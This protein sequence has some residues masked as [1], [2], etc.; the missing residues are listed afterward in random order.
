[1]AR[2]KI[3][4]RSVLVQLGEGVA[5]RIDAVAGSGRRAEYI[6]SAVMAALGEAVGSAPMRPAA[7]PA[8]AVL[9]GPAEVSQVAGAVPSQRSVPLS[10]RTP[11]VRG[12]E[13]RARRA[14]DC[15]VLLDVLRGKRMTVRDAVKELGWAELRLEKVA[16]K[17]MASGLIHCPRG[18]GVMETL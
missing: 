18:N 11:A 17:L 14:D 6:R 4:G 10:E 8:P 16:A 5:E 13:S 2:E 1:M 9:M 15:R 12:A 3:G 7:D